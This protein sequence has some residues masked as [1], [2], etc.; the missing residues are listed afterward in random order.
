MIGP[1]EFSTKE[2]VRALPK[3]VRAQ[4]MRLD[5]AERQ[6]LINGSEHEKEQYGWLPPDAA[7]RFAKLPPTERT[8]EA[9]AGRRAR[10]LE[11]ALPPAPKAAPLKLKPKLLETAA[12]V[13]DSMRDVFELAR[14]GV[15]RVQSMATNFLQTGSDEAQT[16]D[17]VSSVL[18]EEMPLPM[19]ERGPSRVEVMFGG[20]NVLRG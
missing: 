14:E 4:F 9:E 19:C 2:M 6:L 5:K 13:T 10:H 3:E 12:R 20:G 16:I 18:I 1:R 7:K 15:E 11:R 17:Q 8:Q